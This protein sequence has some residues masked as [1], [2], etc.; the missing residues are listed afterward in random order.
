ME[1]YINILSIHRKLYKEYLKNLT[2]LKIEFLYLHTMTNPALTQAQK[3]DARSYIDEDV[4]GLE[5]PEFVIN[6]KIMDI[7]HTYEKVYNKYSKNNNQKLE[8]YSFDNILNKSL[9]NI[10][11]GIYTLWDLFLTG[12]NNL[13]DFDSIIKLIKSNI[14]IIKNNNSS[15]HTYNEMFSALQKFYSVDANNKYIPSELIMKIFEIR[16]LIDKIKDNGKYWLDG[17][18]FEDDAYLINDNP[19]CEY[20]IEIWYNYETKDGKLC[21][22]KNKLIKKVD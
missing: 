16:N 19:N 3:I 7:Y 21:F 5:D 2:E 12:D 18:A 4:Y 1:E 22:A 15:D 9:Y 13:N 6:S 14:N 17:R 20:D 10:I 8:N 11:T